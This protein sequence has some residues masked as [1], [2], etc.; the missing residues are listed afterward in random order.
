MNFSRVQLIIFI[1]A[2]ITFLP[3]IRH[4]SLCAAV[5]EDPRVVLVC[6]PRAVYH[7]PYVCQSEL[8]NHTLSCVTVLVSGYMLDSRKVT[9][10]IEI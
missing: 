2:F 9:F 4:A 7:I 10:L 3:I 6:S 1:D 8:I 5:I